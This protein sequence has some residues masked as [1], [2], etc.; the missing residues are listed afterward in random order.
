MLVKTPLVD[1]VIVNWNSG[2]YL[3]DCIRSIAHLERRAR[4]IASVCVID[5]ASTDHSADLDASVLPLHV[6]R[7]DVNVGFAAA[8][9]A[10]ARRGTADLILF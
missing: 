5:N 9:N 1:I 6:V 4:A 10:G 3:A 8:C 7:N 2:S